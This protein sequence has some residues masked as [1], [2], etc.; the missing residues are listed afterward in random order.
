MC[1]RSC[2]AE[3]GHASAA[4]TPVVDVGLAFLRHSLLANAGVLK[5]LS[6]A[7]R[8]PSNA[9]HALGLH[10]RHARQ[11][12]I[13]NIIN[14]FKVRY[15]RSRTIGL[16]RKGR[17]PRLPQRRCHRCDGVATNRHFADGAAVIQTQPA[18]DALAV[19]H[20]HAWHCLQ[21]VTRLKVP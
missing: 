20:V 14:F 10:Y 6:F 13:R 19:I 18:I 8:R 9:A 15:R 16:L 3:S 2:A 4:D 7:G 21:R 1:Q 17:L 12:F 11:R 5:D